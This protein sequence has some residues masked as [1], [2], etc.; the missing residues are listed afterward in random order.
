MAVCRNL[1]PR[2]V[3]VKSKA[4]SNPFQLLVNPRLFLLRQRGQRSLFD[5]PLRV[6][7]Q[8]VQV[9]FA[10]LAQSVAPRACA[11]GGVERE[12][13]GFG[14]WG[15]LAGGGAHQMT[16]VG[17]HFSGTQVEHG[18]R[19]LAVFQ[20]QL[21]RLPEAVR[22]VGFHH[23]AVDDHLD[24]VG[25]V[26]VQLHAPGDFHHRAVDPGAQETLLGH[27]F[28][29]LAVMPFPGADHRSQKGDGLAGLGFFDAGQNFGIG[30]AHHG[31]PGGG[32]IGGGTAGKQK[33]QE[34]VDLGDRSHR[35][36]GV[37][38]GRFLLNGNH[39][40]Q[41]FDR[42]DVR[43]FQVAHKL[44]RIGRE[45]LHVPTLAFGVQGVKGQGGLSTAA[46][47][48]DDHEFFPRDFQGQVV[49]V[50]F[51]RS[52]NADGRFVF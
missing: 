35:R 18:D 46:Q 4:Q 25:F 33:P 26:A 52:K 31:L 27:A 16:A 5:G 6:G 12:G 48:G 47:P 40:T 50:V 15:S 8:Q 42:V 44:A 19:P 7:H 34:I 41:P 9:D 28:K 21:H 36:P 38:A 24:V 14:I 20:A 2:G 49:Q 13:I 32:G 37:F 45:G 30:V 22:F 10:H 11:L 1:G 29:Q 23:Q 3:E 43:P 39:R 17:R 51:A